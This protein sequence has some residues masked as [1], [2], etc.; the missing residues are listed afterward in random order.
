L[1]NS[2]TFSGSTKAEQKRTSRHLTNSVTFSGATKEATKEDIQ[3]FD[4]QRYLLGMA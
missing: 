4:E 2:V 3:A 1:T